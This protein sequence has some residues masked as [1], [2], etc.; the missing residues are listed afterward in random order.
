MVPVL[1]K[2]AVGNLREIDWIRKIL[3]DDESSP[4]KIA[5]IFIYFTV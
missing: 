1:S 2:I 3:A 4:A 5:I